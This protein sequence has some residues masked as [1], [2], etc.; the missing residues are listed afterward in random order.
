MAMVCNLDQSVRN[1]TVNK[2]SSV[3]ETRK[4]QSVTIDSD[5]VQDA[6]MEPK[7][8]AAN[9]ELVPNLKSLSITGQP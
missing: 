9:R 8:E 3:R 7:K 5:V 2:T 6:F 1:M 4:L